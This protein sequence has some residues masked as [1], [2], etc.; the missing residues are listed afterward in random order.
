VHGATGD[1]A[2]RDGLAEGTNGRRGR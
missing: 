1:C 2:A